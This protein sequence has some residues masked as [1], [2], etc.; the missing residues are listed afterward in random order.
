MASTPYTHNY[1]PTKISRGRTIITLPSP[2]AARTPKPVELKMEKK[3][4]EIDEA[5]VPPSVQKLKGWLVD[6]E[7]QNK[8]HF[9]K[10]SLV[11]KNQ[12]DA[13][14]ENRQEEETKRSNDLSV[15]VPASPKRSFPSKNNAPVS[16]SATKVPIRPKLSAVVET[17]RK[18]IVPAYSSSQKL[19]TGYVNPVVAANRKV[20]QAKV[21]KEEV[22]ATDN[23][24]ASV[25]KL[26]KWLQDDPFDKKKAKPL[27]WGSN[28]ISKSQAYSP[29]KSNG[30]AATAKD[31][32]ASGKVSGRKQWL[33]KAFKHDEEEEQE[34]VPSD[35]TSK[36][37]M[38]ENAFKKSSSDND[39]FKSR[40]EISIDQTLPQNE[41]A[42]E[43]VFDTTFLTCK[44]EEAVDEEEI[45]EFNDAESAHEKECQNDTSI[46]ID[47]ELQE[48][49][50][51]EEGKFWNEEENVASDSEEAVKEHAISSEKDE[52]NET[53]TIGDAMVKDVQITFEEEGTFLAKE[54][55][56]DVDSED[57]VP[58]HDDTSSE[59]KETD[60]YDEASFS[61]FFNQEFSKSLSEGTLEVSPR[62][63]T[64]VHIY[65][66]P[67][68]IAENNDY[69]ENEIKKSG[70]EETASINFSYSMGSSM[71]GSTAP[72]S[73]L[74]DDGWGLSSFEQARMKVVNR[75]E[76]DAK[77]PANR[78]SAVQ[79]RLAAFELKTKELAYK[80]PVRSYKTTWE[81]DSSGNFVRKHKMGAA[82]PRKSLMELP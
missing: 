75:V 1:T 13:S 49:F 8:Q 24:Y 22:K 31:E 72:A 68:A 9:E 61:A 54:E 29:L 62:E 73:D 18:T 69:S 10:N 12:M 23:G 20:W 77:K 52:A 45:D 34:C 63:T 7:K 40:A 79:K 37:L 35:V 43:S 33:Q 76:P 50:E 78:L 38:L 65:F 28:V 67:N 44:E 11:R 15:K 53:D 56:V 14:S 41:D 55:I 71:E 80:E 59:K 17:R 58:A 36:K 82:T 25:E 81:K 48:T 27:R 4:V 70:T 6:F 16:S 3:K 42:N 19:P 2:S 39:P 64:K 32:I 74:D 30:T 57:Y 60:N 47:E 21:L 5:Q 66:P 46:I 51:E 26:S